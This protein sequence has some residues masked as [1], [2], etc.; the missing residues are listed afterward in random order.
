MAVEVRGYGLFSPTVP[1]TSPSDS[2]LLGPLKKNLVGGRFATDAGMK[3]TVACWLQTLNKDFVNAG[4][5]AVLPRCHKHLNVNDNYVEI[6]CVPSVNNVLRIRRR[7]NKDQSIYF[8]FWNF[9]L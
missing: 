1:I 7:Q 4:I 3:Q 9:L 2:R 6:S 8:I 5:Q